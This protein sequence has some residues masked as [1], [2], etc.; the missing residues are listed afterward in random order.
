LGRECGKKKKM[1]KKM[2]YER[3]QKKFNGQ[4][5]GGGET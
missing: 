2:G 5:G 4:R 1:F 3:G